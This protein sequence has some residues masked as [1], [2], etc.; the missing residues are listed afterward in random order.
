MNK[1]IELITRVQTELNKTITLLAILKVAYNQATS[2]T[3]KL[4]YLQEIGK[5]NKKK[6]LLNEKLLEYISA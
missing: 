1:N 3:K 5:L 4:I 2:N 6:K